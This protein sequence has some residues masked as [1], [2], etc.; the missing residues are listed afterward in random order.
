MTAFLYY[1]FDYI[2]FCDSGTC[3]HSKNSGLLFSFLLYIILPTCGLKVFSLCSTLAFLFF[4]SSYHVVFFNH[5]TASHINQPFIALEHDSSNMEYT[6][7]LF[8]PPSKKNLETCQ[9]W[10]S[11]RNYNNLFKIQ[12]QCRSDDLLQHQTKTICIKPSIPIMVTCGCCYAEFTNRCNT[13]HIQ[14]M[15]KMLLL[16]MN[17]TVYKFEWSKTTGWPWNL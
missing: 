1:S 2:L 3:Q 4:F 9:K 12:T 8:W 5:R 10:C 16:H 11:I 13:N 7:Y 17:E 15:K 6:A 14:H